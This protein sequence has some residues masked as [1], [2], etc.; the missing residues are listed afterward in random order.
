MVLSEEEANAAIE[1]LQQKLTKNL[2]NI[3][4]N[5]AECH[6]IVNSEIIPNL[7]KY[8]AQT[9]KIWESSKVMPVPYSR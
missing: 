6:Q 1:R 7:D 4:R 8:K 3:D 2:Q 9:S 5:F